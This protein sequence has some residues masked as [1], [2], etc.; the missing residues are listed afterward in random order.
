MED[1]G[2]KAWRGRKNKRKG[3]SWTKRER[4]NDDMGRRRRDGE[5]WRR[6]RD[7]RERVREGRGN[8]KK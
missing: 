8:E 1:C 3:E 4:Q 7:E 2:E 5:W 6:R